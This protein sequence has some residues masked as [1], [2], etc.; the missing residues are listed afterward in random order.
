M[1]HGCLKQGWMI[2]LAMA[3]LVAVAGCKPKEAANA[4]QIS[5]AQTEGQQNVA[6][7][8]AQAQQDIAAAKQAETQATLEAANNPDPADAA[9][10]N[11]QARGETLK[12]EAEGRYK[13]E[14]AEIDAAFNTEK[15]RC[16]GLPSGDRSACIDAAKAEQERKLS[17][18][19]TRR[20]STPGAG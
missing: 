1:K 20:D 15:Q 16:N 3:S 17:E 19:K 6:E 10:T 9:L 4:E 12:Q 2:P 13:V 8:S 7:A 11:M 5:E 14:S 18:A